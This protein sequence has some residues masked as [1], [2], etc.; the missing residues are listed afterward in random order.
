MESIQTVV[1]L[2]SLALVMACS[3]DSSASDYPVIDG[4]AEPLRS[5]FNDNADKVRA[6]FLASPT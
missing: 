5:H 3:T 6:I 2:A 1:T 4:K